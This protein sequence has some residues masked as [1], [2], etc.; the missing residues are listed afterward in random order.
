MALAVMPLPWF[1]MEKNCTGSTDP[2]NHPAPYPLTSLPGGHPCR[3]WDGRPLRFP[4]PWMHGLPCPGDL[5]NCRFRIYSSLP[6]NMH[7]MVMPS[8][9][10][11][12]DAGLKPQNAIR[13]FLI[14]VAYS[15]RAAV[16]RKPLNCFIVPG[17][18]APL[19]KSPPPE[20]NRFIAENWPIKSSL[21]QRLREVIFQNRIWPN[22][23]QNGSRRYAPHM[24]GSICMKFR[25]TV[26]E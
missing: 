10:L 17:K 15:C 24:T 9:R 6:F 21:T 16:L 23:D 14:L 2:E 3:N 1:G 8:H 26:R 19:K 7:M 13:I 11:R 12:P 22:I 5:A 18:P 25:P 20:A 4:V